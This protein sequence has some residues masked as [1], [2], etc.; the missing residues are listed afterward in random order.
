MKFK[1]ESSKFIK[2]V[3]Y[4][5]NGREVRTLVNEVMQP[6]E[7]SVKWDASGFASGVYFVKMTNGNLFKNIKLVLIK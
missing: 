1:V 2:L 5:I 7:H 3:V 6:G 4:D